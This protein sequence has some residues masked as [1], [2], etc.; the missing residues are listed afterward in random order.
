MFE[1]S[2]LANG[3][4]GKRAWTTMM[5]MTGQVALV[6]LA[7]LIPMVSPQVLPMAKIDLRLVPPVPPGPPR[8]GGEEVKR[9][10]ANKTATLKRFTLA[11][12]R[13]QPRDVPTQIWKGVEEPPVGAYVSGLPEGL[14]T[15]IG[16]IGGYPFAVEAPRVSPPA[17]IVTTAPKPPEAPPE[18]VRRLKE[19]GLVQLGQ[20]LR[21]GEL[22]YPQVARATR[23]EGQVV[24]ECVVGTDGRITEVKVKSGSPLLVKAAVEAAWKWLYTPSRLNGDP[25]EIITIMTFNF[26]L[27]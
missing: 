26:K 11:L 3:P 13:Y 7:I 20:V 2:M 25:I 9:Q 18:P 6:S 10:P 4:V 5:G 15:R 16:V 21:R 8:L 14:G 22:L 17:P 19:G 1:Q 24:L 23:T 12:D 27:N